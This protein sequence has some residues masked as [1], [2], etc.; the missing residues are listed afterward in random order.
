MGDFDSGRMGAG[1]EGGE[2]GEGSATAADMSAAS[3]A[4]R[5]CGTL[6]MLMSLPMQNKC[7]R[8]GV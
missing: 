2:C 8:S 3:A 7:N 6:L 4:I 1:G 5:D